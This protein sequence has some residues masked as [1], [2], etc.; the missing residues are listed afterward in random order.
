MNRQISF[1]FENTLYCT[2]YGASDFLQSKC[3]F[4]NVLNSNAFSSGG[5]VQEFKKVANGINRPAMLPSLQDCKIEKDVVN[6]I[7]KGSGKVNIDG[8]TYDAT[9]DDKALII[10]GLEDTVPKAEEVT[11]KEEPVTEEVVVE[12]EEVKEEEVVAEPIKEEVTEEPVEEVTEDSVVEETTSEVTKTE[13]VD[14]EP[15]M[16]EPIE[17]R[18]RKIGVSFGNRSAESTVPKPLYSES[19]IRPMPGI[20][21]GAGLPVPSYV[22]NNPRAVASFRE[23]SVTGRPAPTP[24]VND[25]AIKCNKVGKV[26]AQAQPEVIEAEEQCENKALSVKEKEDNLM[27]TW[28]ETAAPDITKKWDKQLSEPV[29]QESV[30]EDVPTKSNEQIEEITNAK[31]AFRE[32]VDSAIAN[33][34]GDI[35]LTILEPIA[36]FTL[37]AVDIDAL[38]SK[39]DGYCIDNR[40]HK[41]GKW[42]C[43][44]VVNAGAR[45]FY[46]S[47]LDVSIQIELKCCNE[48]LSIVKG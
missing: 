20:S 38:N 47:K 31:K 7:M 46:N 48:W 10:K 4:K 40:W 32:K 37:N 11:K 1:V 14:D 39:G 35:P 16:N 42:Y 2:C 28:R 36:E 19:T 41:C 22:L 18:V 23:R 45:Y 21:F 6:H 25:L 24:R 12:V 30:P 3:D 34:I 17:P 13:S 5:T 8:T 44:D 9:F 27:N 33:V 15:F 29:K 26:V 43:I